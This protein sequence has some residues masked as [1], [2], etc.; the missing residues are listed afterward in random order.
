M[1]STAL[2]NTHRGSITPNP[3]PTPPDERGGGLRPGALLLA[4]SYR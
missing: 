1:P 3:L 4:A 2:T